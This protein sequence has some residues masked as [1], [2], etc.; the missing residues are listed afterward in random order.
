[1]HSAARCWVSSAGAHTDPEIPQ[2]VRWISWGLAR[3]SMRLI[4]GRGGSVVYVPSG[5]LCGPQ[6][7]VDV[8]A[9]PLRVSEAYFH[10]LC[11]LAARHGD[12]PFVWP[13]RAWFLAVHAWNARLATW[14]QRLCPK[15]EAS[16]DRGPRVCFCLKHFAFAGI[17]LSS[18]SVGIRRGGWSGPWFG[19]W[20]PFRD[21]RPIGFFYNWV[22]LELFFFYF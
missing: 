14:A 11:A 2:R 1:M 9:A 20:G 18:G 19:I 4:C 17:G 10:A 12:F 6:R 15:F 5:E 21:D 7:F 22:I 16:S 13:P 8:R 3:E